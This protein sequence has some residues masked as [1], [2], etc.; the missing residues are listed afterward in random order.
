M[1][2]TINFAVSVRLFDLHGSGRL[3]PTN[4]SEHAYV[5]FFT[6]ICPDIEIFVKIGQK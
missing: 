5:D 2:A 1:L 4:F 3:P 6:K